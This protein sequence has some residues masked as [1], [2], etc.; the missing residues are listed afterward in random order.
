MVNVSNDKATHQINV[1]VNKTDLDFINAKARRYN[2]SR[3]ALMKIAALN[4]ELT[5]EQLDQPLRMPKT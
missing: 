1:K 5:V 3:S 2:I 4:V